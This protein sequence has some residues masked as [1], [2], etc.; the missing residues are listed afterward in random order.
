MGEI[1]EPLEIRGDGLSP[2]LFNM[3]LDKIIKQW[4][5]QVKGVQLGRIRNTRTIIECLAFADNLAILSNNRQEAQ[6]ALE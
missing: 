2:L 6:E 5:E 3:V 4:E 1:S